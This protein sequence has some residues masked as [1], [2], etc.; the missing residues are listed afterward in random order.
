MKNSTMRAKMKVL[1]VTE[2]GYE[3]AATGFVK[4]QEGLSFSAVCKEDGYPEDGLDENNT[5]AKWT[6]SATINICVTN[7]ALFGQFKEGESYYVDF[8]K[9]DA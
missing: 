7:P 4:T 6:P 9:A 5:F 1:A 2:S 8:T 3:N